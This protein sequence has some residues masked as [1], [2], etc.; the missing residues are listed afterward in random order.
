MT[1][2]GSYRLDV[3]RCGCVLDRLWPVPQQHY[4]ALQEEVG[5]KTLC[6]YIH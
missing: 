4:G 3:A 2:T 6:S 1:L 5:N